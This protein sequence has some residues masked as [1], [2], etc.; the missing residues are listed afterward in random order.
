MKPTRNSK[1]SNLDPE[2]E[3]Q[4][5]SPVQPVA[6]G[7]EGFFCFCVGFLSTAGL[8]DV[9]F[10]GYMGLNKQSRGACC[11]DCGVRGPGL[12]PSKSPKPI[13]QT[14]T[15]A[16]P[17]DRARRRK[18][19]HPR[20]PCLMNLLFESASGPFTHVQTTDGCASKQ[21]I[22]PCPDGA[23]PR[24]CFDFSNVILVSGPVASPALCQ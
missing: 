14:V 8:E 5:S 18:S 4:S 17:A 2:L 3:S 1:P 9:D 11:L 22:C 23:T 20:G 13:P 16:Q 7:F 15:R 24:P 6:L 19:G 21:N 10:H 12:N